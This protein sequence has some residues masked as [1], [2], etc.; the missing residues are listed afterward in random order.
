MAEPECHLADVAGGLEHQ[1]GTT[2]PKLVGR[3]GAPN[4]SGVSG[5]SG[6]R[7]LVENVFEP[8][9]CHRGAFSVDEELWDKGGSAYR[10]PGS[11]ISGGLFP[12]RKRPLL[13]ALS[14]DTDARCPVE[15][16]LRQRKPHQFGDAQPAGETEVQ[17]SAVSNTEACRQI[18]GVED[19]PH[20][21]DRE[22]P[23]QRL[24][25]A[26]CRNGV[27]LPDLFQ[28]GGDAEFDVPHERLDRRKPRIAG[29]CVVMTLLLDVG[30]E[31]EHQGGV[32]VLEAEL[33]GSLA[34]TLA[35][36]DEQQ[37]ESVRVRLASVRTI[38][39]LD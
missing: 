16:D 7:V 23:H 15:R 17:H 38:S 36:K 28:G 11:E 39:P 9:P 19:C 34:Q 33:R 13:A 21:A 12:K 22:V 14:K 18:R 31:V 37:P 3:H 26:L 20:L 29:R 27:D 25:M 35:G 1:Y 30:Q 8:G 4:Q 24:V 32:D 10:Q 2:V 6:A 5:G